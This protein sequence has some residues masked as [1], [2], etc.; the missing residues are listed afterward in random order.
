MA[1]TLVRHCRPLLGTFVEIAVPPRFAA[2]VEPAFAAIAAVHER[3]SFHAES[4]DLAALR[5]AAVGTCVEVGSGTMAVLG[6]A[7]ILY[8]RSG[9]LFDVAIGARLVAAGFLPRPAG[10]DLRRMTGT[11]ADLELLSANRV[12]LHRPMLIDLGGIAKGYAVDR[13]ID[14][15]IAAGT[16]EAVVNAGGDLRVIGTEPVTVRGDEGTP[17]FTLALSD[18][19]IAT[20]TPWADRRCWR[21]AIAVPHLG[22]GRLPLATAGSV[23]VVADRCMVADAMTKIALADRVLAAAMLAD[24]GGCLVE[25]PALRRAA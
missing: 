8:E 19:A 14:V 18:A 4:S 16:D 9:G 1:E 20:S 23:S 13:A 2:L 12:R 17:A 5:R 3:M 6:F 22:R 7:R 15:L 24:L 21:G 10:I 11:S 25:P